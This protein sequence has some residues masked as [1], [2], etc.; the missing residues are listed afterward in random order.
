MMEQIEQEVAD[1]II[2]DPLFAAVEVH[3]DPEKNI[4]ATIEQK[5]AKLKR[6]VA[7]VVNGAGVQKPDVFGPYFDEINIDIGIFHNPIMAGAGPTVRAMAERVAALIHLWKPDSLS[8]PLKCAPNC[9]GAIPDKKL[10]VWSVKA[11]A[12]GGL[13]YVL[14]QLAEVT[15]ARFGNEIQLSCATAGAAIFYTTDGKHPTPRNGTYIQSGGLVHLLADGTTVKARAWLAGYLA[16]E[17][18]KETYNLV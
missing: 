10:N 16:S 4:V 3:V 15:A 1:R 5:L 17:Q 2:S 8:V 12:S 18:F 11:Q 7:P 14:P 9:L 6:L 13:T